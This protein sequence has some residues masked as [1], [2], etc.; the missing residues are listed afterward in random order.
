MK[1]FSYRAAALVVLLLPCLPA[2]AQRVRYDANGQ[3]DV[4]AENFTL[5][6]AAVIRDVTGQAPQSR[7]QVVFFR[8]DRPAADAGELLV[9]E[10]GNALHA[11]A[12]G[13]YFVAVVPPGLHRYHVDGQSLSLEVRPGRCYYVRVAGRGVDS[14]LSQS[15]AMVFLNA[16][17]SRP[18]PRL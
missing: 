15:N 6:E 5:V 8:S 16:T 11:L 14:R 1:R 18:L 17:G 3:A 12:A 2:M 13:G 4:V 7:G 9:R 10:K